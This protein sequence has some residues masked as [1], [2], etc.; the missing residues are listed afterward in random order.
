MTVPPAPRP[1]APTKRPPVT[2]AELR[3]TEV[4][5]IA[6]MP[7]ILRRVLGLALRYHGRILI[8][9][10]ATLGTAGISLLLPRLL[11]AA[12][13]HAHKLLGQGLTLGEAVAQLGGSAAIILLV[14]VLRGLLRMVAGYEGE[15]IGQNVGHDLRLAFFEKLQRLGF[16]FH[17]KIH[18]GDL[19]TRGMLDLE[20]VR[21]FIGEGVQRL[22]L[23]VLLVGVGAARLYSADPLMATLALSF[24]PFVA[25]QAARTGFLM[26]VTWTRLQEKMGLL[27]R[28]ME[29]NL[30]GVRVVRAFAA[31]AFEMTRFD[32]AAEAA[33]R[34]AR[35][36]IG[37]RALSI[38]SMQAAF[39]L[40]MTVVLVVGGS[41]ITA[42]RM[43][44][45]QLTEILAFMTIL[46]QPV[47]QIIMI[48]NSAARATSSGQRLFEVLDR[49]PVIRDRA[50][51]RTLEAPEG[52]LRFEHVDFAYEG[53]P[54]VLSDI[55][56]EVRPGRTL[57]I[58]GAPGAGKSTIAHLIPRF[59]DV[60]GGRITLDGQDIRE[61]TLDSLRSA[62]ALI[63]QDVF[64]FDIAASANI[65]Y[66]DPDAEDP[67]IVA[68]ATDARI[69]EHLAALPTG[70]A[71]RIGERGVSLS[72]GQR[73]RLS[74]ARGGL[75]EP[76]VLILD[77]SLSA[78]DT[79]T[80]AALRQALSG[81][82]TDRA[83]LI[84][85]HRLSSIVHADEIIVLEGGRIAE[86]GT[87]AQLLARDGHYAA[88]HRL[89]SGGAA[90]ADDRR[91]RVPA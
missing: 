83:T 23:V 37:L 5:D 16:D 74:I 61:L 78:V 91:S 2:F 77:D 68:A 57:G 35:F 87:H 90:A 6:A 75:P 43:T 40:A 55:S 7:R 15:V 63:A 58:V 67:R 32:A 70:Y 50:G 65:A 36:R 20:G 56:F 21:G 30:Q 31:E 64:L 47:R 60:T 84:I 26:R 33:L 81:A 73:Q 19:I 54:P 29:E 14:A 41:R 34:I 76:A 59:Y 12:V 17:D 22:V 66:A 9:T 10:L 8:A 18:S 4:V 53:G 89:Q 28:Q 88:L 79:A 62:V 39:Y 45:G 3:P 46:Q 1:V 72:G 44:V 51:A 69:H 42:G 25:V 13:D 24:V 27:T 48:V 86:R 38:T 85:A 71:T 52:V 49:E 80:E 11:G 82:A